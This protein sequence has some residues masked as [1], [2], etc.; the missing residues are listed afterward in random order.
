M[1][2]DGEAG[3]GLAP[4]TPHPSSLA[5]PA[6]CRQAP[7]VGAVCGNPARTD[8]CGGRSAMGVPTANPEPTPTTPR[9][10]RRRSGTGWQNARTGMSTSPR[11]RVLGSTRSSGSSPNSPKS[12]SAEAL[13]DQPL[14]SRPPFRL[15]SRRPTPTRSPSN[16]PSRPPNS[17]LHPAVLR[18]DTP[19]G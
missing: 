4:E 11:H 8:L 7:E 5:E 6:V 14:N 12:R 19:N 9:T 1:G 2:A 18:Q 10:R 15:T 13:T 17:R 16:G 3:R